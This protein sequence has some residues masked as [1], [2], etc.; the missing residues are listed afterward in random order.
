MNDSQDVSVQDPLVLEEIGLLGDLI[1]MASTASLPL[2][3]DQIDTAPGIVA[4]VGAVPA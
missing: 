3:Q 4:A 2:S 1:V